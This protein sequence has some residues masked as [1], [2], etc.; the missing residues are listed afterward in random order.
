[1]IVRAGEMICEYLQI[2]PDLYIFNRPN[3]EPTIV[4]YQDP[5]QFM[6]PAPKKSKPIE[7][8]GKDKCIEILHS[9]VQTIA[10]IIKD[11]ADL[12]IMKRW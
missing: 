11:N 1:V 8:L 6:I 3:G 5:I 9:L 7:S 4:E 10:D 12:A 2:K